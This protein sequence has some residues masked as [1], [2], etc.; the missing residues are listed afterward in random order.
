MK[1]KRSDLTQFAKNCAYGANQML[2]GVCVA[3]EISTSDIGKSLVN[4][5]D[6]ELILEISKRFTKYAK[7]Q[8]GFDIFN[9]SVQDF[10]N[11]VQMIVDCCEEHNWFE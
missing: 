8:M 7:D 11:I 1:Y 3:E 6:K 9:G 4:I 2:N 10:Q 5:E